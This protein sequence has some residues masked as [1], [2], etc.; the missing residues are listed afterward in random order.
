MSVL[1]GESQTI[2]HEIP[3]RKLERE[4]GPGWIG[5]VG[6][7]EV[8][9][10]CPLGNSLHIRSAISLPLKDTGEGDDRWG[11]RTKRCGERMG[12]SGGRDM[13]RGYKILTCYGSDP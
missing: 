2:Y 10:L 12:R 11:R 4:A 13:K 7:T 1:M 8:I 5:P 3:G 9:D 6:I